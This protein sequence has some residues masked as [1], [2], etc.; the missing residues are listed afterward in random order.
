MEPISHSRAAQVAYQDLLRMHLDEAAA[1][2]V[3][4]VGPTGP[5]V[6]IWTFE[7]TYKEQTGR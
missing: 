2:I 1:E 6:H 7:R 3:G 4:S 5:S